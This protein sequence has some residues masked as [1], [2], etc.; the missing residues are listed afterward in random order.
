MAQAFRDGKAVAKDPAEAAKWFEKAAEGIGCTTSMVNLALMHLEGTGV[1]KDDVKAMEWFR[2]AADGG[3]SYAM[4]QLGVAYY[5]GHGVERSYPEALSWFRKSADAGQG[6]SMTWIGEMHELGQAVAKN[7]TEA[8]AWYRRAIDTGD[9]APLLFLGRL[10]AE[11]RGVEKSETEA[12]DLFRRAARAKNIEPV[13]SNAVWLVGD[14]DLGRL[15]QPDQTATLMM[16]TLAEFPAFRERLVAEASKFPAS[17]RR[18]IQASL[19]RAGVYRGKDDGSFGPTTRAALD[20]YAA[21][22]TITSTSSAPVKAGRVRHI[23]RPQN[24]P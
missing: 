23:S 11:G 3:D 21:R 14:S 10:Y 5:G 20:A 4:S 8:A 2:R 13:W 22:W 19:K 7:E 15:G 24:R 18:A 9:L 16:L 6:N 12:R 17:V 1:P